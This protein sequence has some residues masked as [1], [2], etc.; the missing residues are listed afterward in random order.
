MT[1]S[2]L[3]DEIAERDSGHHFELSA[4]EVIED[5]PPC[6]P[7]RGLSDEPDAQSLDSGSPRSR[8]VSAPSHPAAVLLMRRSRPCSKELPPCSSRR[9]ADWGAKKGVQRS[10]FCF[11]CFMS[12]FGLRLGSQSGPKPAALNWYVNEPVFP[13]AVTGSM[14]NSCTPARAGLQY[15]SR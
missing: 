1:R 5:E 3:N 2:K 8:M 4:I 9:L 7:R 11:G 6:S 12:K 10:V 13:S 15:E 14:D